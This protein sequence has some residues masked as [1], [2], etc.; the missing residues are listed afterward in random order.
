MKEGA[1]QEM[2]VFYSFQLTQR[3][4]NLLFEVRQLKRSNK[5]SKYFTDRNGH[6]KI[7]I[8]VNDR[9]KHRITYFWNR[10]ETV[11]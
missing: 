11:T 8:G 4:S 1:G 6:F 10:G 5:V 7:R 2:N 9:D 3:R